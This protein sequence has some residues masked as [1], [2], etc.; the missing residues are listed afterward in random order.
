MVGGIGDDVY[1]GSPIAILIEL[2]G[3]DMYR[4]AVGSGVEGIG[5]AIDLLGDDHYETANDF[6][7]GAGDLGIGVFLDFDGNDRYAKETWG[8]EKSWTQQSY[9]AG[10][11]LKGGTPLFTKTMQVK[12]RPPLPA[13]ASKIDPVDTIPDVANTIEGA[14]ELF[15]IMVEGYGSTPKA[16]K[17]QEKFMSMGE[18]AIAVLMENL[19]QKPFYRCYGLGYSL[20][21]KFGEKAVPSLLELWK[22]EDPWLRCRAAEAL[23]NLKARAAVPALKKA[24]EDPYYQ[25]RYGA[26]RAIDKIEG[27][28]QKK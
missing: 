15:E 19:V 23:G 18:H 7:C 12:T 1:D 21:P 22:N 5:M 28:E 6:V 8:N 9:G 20:L 2:G 3:D 14:R 16:K 24:A 13:I 4:C 11:D 10:V 25:V 27:K 17:A 26:Q